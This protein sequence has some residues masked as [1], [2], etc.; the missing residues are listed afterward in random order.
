MSVLDQI[1]AL[2]N[3]LATLNSYFSQLQQAKFNNV[4]FF[5]RS[6]STVVGRRNVEHIY[7]FRDK[8]W[9][10]DVGMRA[11][12]YHIV[13]FLVGDDVI[14]QRNALQIALVH[15]GPGLLVHPT[16]GMLAVS[17]LECTFEEDVS[18]GRVIEVHMSFEQCGSRAF[19]SVTADTGNTVANK[20][21]TAMQA[22]GNSF[23]AQVSP[24]LA[25]V[26]GAGTALATAST[27][28]GQVQT[29]GNDAS[30]VMHLASAMSGSFGR[31]AGG[32]TGAGSGSIAGSYVSPSQVTSQVANLINTA[33]ASRS[34][35]AS[36]VSSLTSALGG[37]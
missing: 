24:S 16:Y 1:F 4:P 17:V 11:R 33:S 21:A 7:P 36:G 27:W 10:E 31:I 14:A 28:V 9:M 22:I 15:K 13:G 26:S 3:P 23:G 20:S 2:S 35:I 5:T 18:H 34:S 30:N 12:K 32:A 29:L 6:N 19:P 25:A 8:P 37:L